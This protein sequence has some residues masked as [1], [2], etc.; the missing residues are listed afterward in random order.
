MISALAAYR[1]VRLAEVSLFS[2]APKHG[3][4]QRGP[5]SKKDSWTDGIVKLLGSPDFGHP[6]IKNRLLNSFCGAPT[7]C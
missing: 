6:E 5:L 2:S 3:E 4:S 7:L 1:F